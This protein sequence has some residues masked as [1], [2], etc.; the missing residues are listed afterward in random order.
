MLHWEAVLGACTGQATVTSCRDR[1]VRVWGYLGQ[2]S[3]E[4]ITMTALFCLFVL[5]LA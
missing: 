3:N 5:F 4:H 1:H 2:S